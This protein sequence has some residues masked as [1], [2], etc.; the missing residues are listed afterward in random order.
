MQS[1]SETD[2]DRAVAAGRAA[3][4][5]EFRTRSVRY[6]ADRDMVEIVT[7]RGAGLLVPRRWIGALAG[8]A[9]QHLA[10]LDVW[11]DGSAIEIAALDI[12]I[13]VH[14]LLTEL[15]PALLP[16]GALAGLFASRGGQST[17]P[18]KKAT[19][20]ANGRKGGRPP[21]PTTPEAA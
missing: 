11:P 21:K 2:I 15:L 8:V 6:L 17:S 12:Q 1:I 19:A 7:T 13:S 18:A 3:A 9:P 4:D 20:R 5:S 14:G 10:G 16:A